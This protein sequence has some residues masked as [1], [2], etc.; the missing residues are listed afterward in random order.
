MAHDI[1]ATYLVEHFPGHTEFMVLTKEDWQTLVRW[2]QS[3]GTVPD[4]I[5]GLHVC[6]IEVFE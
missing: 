3:L 1:T 5:K 4:D 6:E 2:C